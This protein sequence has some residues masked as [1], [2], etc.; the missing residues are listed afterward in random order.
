MDKPEKVLFLVHK[1]DGSSVMAAFPH[2][3]GTYNPT[4]MLSYE[5]VG[6]H[7]SVAMDYVS[8]CRI[9]SGEEAQDLKAELERLGY[10]LDVRT[11]TGI[12][13]RRIREAKLKDHWQKVTQT[14]PD[15]R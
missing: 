3:N 5:H 9:A 6:Q 10:V 8:E 13:D 15:A 1:T 2:L 14:N 7:G 4:I 12:Q 11:T